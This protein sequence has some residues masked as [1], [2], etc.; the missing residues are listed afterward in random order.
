MNIVAGKDL[1]WRRASKCT[2]GHCV[3]VAI[4]DDLVLVRDSKQVDLA[5][6]QPVLTFG[7]D[8]WRAFADAIT[9]GEFNI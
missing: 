3:E 9:V 7:A 1:R 2:G 4:R 6:D 8:E 5:E